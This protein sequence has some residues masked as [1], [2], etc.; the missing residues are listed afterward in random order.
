MPRAYRLGQRR[1]AIEDTRVRILAAAREMLAQEPAPASFSVEAIA[2]QADVSRMTVYYQF[3]SRAGLLAAL[4]DD[5]ASRGHL[6][7]DLPAAFSQP[8]PVVALQ[9]FI[10]AFARFWASSQP[11]M[12][13]LYGFAT[14]DPEL[15]QSLRQRNEGRT[16][17]LRVI[18]GRIAQQHGRPDPAES[19]E[20]VA[21]LFM[22]TSF[23]T[24][25][26]LSASELPADSIVS[27]VIRLAL[28]HL[29]LE[30]PT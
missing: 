8:D 2:R 22:L 12:R 24:F 15:S 28:S 1:A 3:E 19:D 10:R 5:F 23:A 27:L 13:R 16:R 4:F 17:G 30:Q 26:T 21:A 20:T 18:L 14:L 9:E 11:V 29:G 25:D 6:A 7:S